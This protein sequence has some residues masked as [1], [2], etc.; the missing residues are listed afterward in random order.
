MSEEAVSEEVV[1]MEKADYICTLTI[2]RPEKRNA[3]TVEVMYRLG[4]ALHAA[5]DDSDVRVVVLRGAGEKAFCAGLDLRGGIQVSEGEK[6][7]KGDPL[8]YAR[9]NVMACTKPVIAMIYRNAL[10]AGCDLAAACDIRV[11]SDTARM[12]INPVKLGSV[13][14]PEAIRNLMNVV[15]LAWAKELFFT[16]RFIDVQTAKEIGLVNYVVPEEELPAKTYGLAQEIAENG[17]LAVSGTKAIFNKLLMYQELSAEDMAEIQALRE[18]VLAS[19]DQREGM[20]A[21]MEKR[22]ADFK[23]R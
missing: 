18:S 19:E 5:N 6:L 10:G 23:G 12:G 8:G 4:D 17:P 9:R 20:I 15:G 3:L 14:W 11:A 2:N 16:G 22:K 21:F 1:L 13:Y 7:E